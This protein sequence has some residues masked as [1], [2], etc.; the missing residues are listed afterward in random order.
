VKDLGGSGWEL[1]RSTHGAPAVVAALGMPTWSLNKRF[2]LAFFHDNM[3]GEL[4]PD[5]EVMVVMAAI[6]IEK[7][8]QET[9]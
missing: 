7:M 8:F 2:T 6:W 5:F 1:V 9:R 3:P 4:G